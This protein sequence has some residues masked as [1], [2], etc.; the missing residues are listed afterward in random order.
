M[1]S[2][3]RNFSRNLFKYLWP[4][5]WPQ[6]LTI[7]MG[8]MLAAAL[9]WANTAI[10]PQLARSTG[11][12]IALSRTQVIQA[13]N[14]GVIENIPVHEGDLIKKG[15]LLMQL[16]TA[17]L[18]AAVVDSRAKVAALEA[19]LARLHAEVFERPLVFPA[20][21]KRYPAFVEN[22]TELYIRRQRALH[23]EIA[24][25]KDML[26]HVNQELNMSLPLL[27]SGDIAQTEILRLK[28]SQAELQ[29]SLTNRQ[30]RYFQDAQADMTK[31]EEDLSSQRQ[32]LVDRESNL[33][34]MQIFAPTDGFV[35]NIRVTTLGGRVRP[36]DIVMDLFPTDSKLIVEA[37]LKTS[38]L[39][40]IQLNQPS[41]IKLDAYDYSIY[42]VLN[43]KV[44]YV[45]P[46]ALSENSPQGEHIFYRVH[47]EI[48][49]KQEPSK[50]HK[51]IEIMPGMTA[52]V[53]IRTGQ[54]TVLDYLLKPIVKTVTSAFTE[55]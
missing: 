10:I 25:L 55:R 46:D 38:D 28:R 52:Q 4:D 13:A 43:G 3:K 21:V 54:M 18:N 36:G 15:Q 31:A 49:P 12:I 16:D 27:A 5:E 6:R 33:E 44:I 53:E 35:R 24:T 34:R 32:M 41:T 7:I 14:D 45:S 50:R 2:S 9:W 11:Q 8:L 22:Q 17:Q 20:E 51:P 40:H 39:A 29:G 26:S 19:T 47:I 23:E 48:D 42:G 30:N 1:G 37:K